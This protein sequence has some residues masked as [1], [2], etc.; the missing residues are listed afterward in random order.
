MSGAGSAAFEAG[1]RYFVIITSNPG[2]NMLFERGAYALVERAQRGELRD[3]TGKRWSV[4][5]DGLVSGT[6]E[7]LCRI[8]APRAFRFGWV[9]Q[10]PQSLLHK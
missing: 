1:G 2:A 3:T 4:S 5:A 9:A 8:P 7:R 10:C 6:G